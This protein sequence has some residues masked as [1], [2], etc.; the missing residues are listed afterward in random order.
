MMEQDRLRD[1]ASR[2]LPP[3]EPAVTFRNFYD[4]LGY[5][6]YMRTDNAAAPWTIRRYF[7]VA[8]GG[9]PFPIAESFGFDG[10]RDYSVDLDGDGRRE[11]VANVQYGGDGHRTVYVYQRR[12]DGIW[13]GVPDLSGLPDHD[14]WGANST[15]V[16]F[17]PAGR[18]FRV[19]YAMKNTETLGTVEYQGL[20]RMIFAPYIPT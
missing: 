5:N 9:R 14:N 11:L 12:E 19:R 7:A 4:I 17:D 6:G 1:N 8:E 15:A 20:G 18:V 2:V 16:V 3:S 13:R 10:P